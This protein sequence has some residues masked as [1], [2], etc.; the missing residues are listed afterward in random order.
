MTSNHTQTHA[1]CRSCNYQACGASSKYTF[2]QEP[3]L[4]LPHHNQPSVCPM[5]LHFWRSKLHPLHVSSWQL[6]TPSKESEDNGDS[7][8]HSKILT[9][10]FRT[11]GSCIPPVLTLEGSK[12][13][14]QFQAAWPKHLC[15]SSRHSQ[16]RAS[17]SPVDI[18][19]LEVVIPF[20]KE[21]GKLFLEKGSSCPF[22]MHPT[23]MLGSFLFKNVYF[24]EQ[25]LFNFCCSFSP[26]NQYN[27]LSKV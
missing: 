4:S 24:G 8:L 12:Y 21:I 13:T 5:P 27:T 9:L 22:P 15:S 6:S 2:S 25:N 19:H 26:A 10:I 11:V 23:F 18:C 20:H 14:P 16:A 7:N 17:S 1:N 3:S